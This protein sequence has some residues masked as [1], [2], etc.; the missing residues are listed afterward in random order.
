MIVAFSGNRF[1]IEEALLAELKGQGRNPSDLP[2]LSGEDLT[3]ERISMATQ[4]LF[5]PNQL[6]LDFEGQSDL[7]GLLGSL[8]PTQGELFIIDP[9]A[10][11]SRIKFYESNGRHRAVPAPKKPG[12]VIQWIFGRCKALGLSIERDAAVYLGQVFGDGLALIAAE[13]NKL[14]MLSQKI[15][16]E[17]AKKYVQ[18]KEPGQVFALLDA[19]VGGDAPKSIRE[20]QS[21]IDQGDEPFQILGTVTWQYML[22]ARTVA[23]LQNQPSLNEHQLAEYLKIKPF[24]AKKAL[25]AVRNRG[26]AFVLYSLR[27]IL[28]TEFAMK[29]GQNAVA[30]LERLVFHL[31]VCDTN[32]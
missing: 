29:S 28:K 11:P 2:Q 31:A 14:S 1:L 32:G 5:S 12:D 23:A 19:M 20:L 8:D 25:G 6:V 13:L 17:Q 18:L 21:L 26:E 9:S 27:E 4:G 24:P 30:S 15:T 7:K 22:L 10:T 3:I 16:L